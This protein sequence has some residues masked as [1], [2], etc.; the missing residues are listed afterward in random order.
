ML[1]S[2]FPDLY[3]STYGISELKLSLS[4]EIVCDTCFRLTQITGQ[5]LDDGTMNDHLDSRKP[6]FTV[7]ASNRLRYMRQYPQAPVGSLLHS[8]EVIVRT[9]QR[10]Q[11]L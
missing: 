3:R 5:M 11:N 6:G 2:R 9:D 8:V 10:L 4:P 7:H 1:E